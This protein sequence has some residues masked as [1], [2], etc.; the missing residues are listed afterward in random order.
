[1]EIPSNPPQYIAEALRNFEEHAKSP[2]SLEAEES[3]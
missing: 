3:E 1:L 2:P